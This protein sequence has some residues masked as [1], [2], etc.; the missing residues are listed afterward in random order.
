MLQMHAFGRKMFLKLSLLSVLSSFIPK[1]INYI[2]RCKPIS[3]VGAEQVGAVRRLCVIIFTF[4]NTQLVTPAA[5]LC[6]SCTSSSSWTL[7]L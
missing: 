6:V 3:M 4:E 5:L 2:F 7:I 1:F